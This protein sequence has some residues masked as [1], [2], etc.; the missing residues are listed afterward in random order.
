[1]ISAAAKKEKGKKENTQKQHKA[2]RKEHD[3]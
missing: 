3:L 2:N 1:V